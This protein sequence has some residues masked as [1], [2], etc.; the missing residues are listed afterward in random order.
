M[1]QDVRYDV[2]SAMWVMDHTCPY[3]ET[4]IWEYVIP[5]NACC[6]KKMELFDA[7]AFTE[8]RKRACNESEFQGDRIFRQHHD[9][10]GQ[11]S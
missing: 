5:L 4:A 1:G 7:L 8:Q 9:R 2:A 11:S 6:I 10:S 3:S